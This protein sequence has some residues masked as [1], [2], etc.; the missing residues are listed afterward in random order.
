MIAKLCVL[1]LRVMRAVIERVWF[2]RLGVRRVLVRTLLIPAAI[3][4]DSF[5]RWY[6]GR[7]CGP[8]SGPRSGPEIGAKAPRG[9]SEGAAK[10]EAFLP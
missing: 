10:R 4:N 6:K 5:I 7:D 9:T 1:W 8:R 3:I 2:A